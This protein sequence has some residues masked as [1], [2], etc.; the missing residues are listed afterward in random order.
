MFQPAHGGLR[1]ALAADGKRAVTGGEGN[2]VQVWDVDT[3]KVLH[4]FT[5]PG[6]V[7]LVTISPDGRRAYA[8]VSVTNINHVQYKIHVFDLHSGLLL[9]LQ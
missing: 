8:S 3:G 9:S 2:T 6:K 4:T 7:G 1:V 5:H